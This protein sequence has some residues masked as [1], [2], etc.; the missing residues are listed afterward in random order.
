MTGAPN[1]RNRSLGLDWQIGHTSILT[2][3]VEKMHFQEN[4][5][6]ISMN[7]KALSFKILLKR[8]VFIQYFHLI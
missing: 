5:S 3:K 2:H 8:Q 1:T 7:D 6:S 4:K